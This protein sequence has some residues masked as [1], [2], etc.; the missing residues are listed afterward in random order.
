[1]CEN[2]DDKVFVEIFLLVDQGGEGVRVVELGHLDDFDVVVAV[3]DVDEEGVR[4]SLVRENLLYEKAFL[5]FGCQFEVLECIT[6]FVENLLVD[7]LTQ[8]FR[9]SKQI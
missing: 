6:F 5:F 2:S 1:M 8:L 7:V 4:E 3:D 9:L